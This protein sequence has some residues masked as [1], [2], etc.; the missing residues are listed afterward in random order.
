[1]HLGQFLSSVLGKVTQAVEGNHVAPQA[2]PAHPVLTHQQA[3]SAHYDDQRPL[4]H[5]L[6]AA[7]FYH[8]ANIGHGV[9]ITNGLLYTDQ[10]QPDYTVRPAAPVLNQHP[11][12]GAYSLP[13]QNYASP[14]Q[15]IPNAIPKLP[16]GRY[17]A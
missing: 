11:V 13:G 14:A 1:M 2:A 4:V 17:S 12:D 6:P 8:T 3:Q 10:N 7:T 9:P 15:L 16:L 5:G